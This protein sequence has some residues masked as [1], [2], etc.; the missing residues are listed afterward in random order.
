MATLQARWAIEELSGTY[1]PSPQPTPRFSSWP[2]GEHIVY[3]LEDVSGSSTSSDSIVVSTPAGDEI[4]RI[5]VPDCSH[6][7][8]SPS[9]SML[10]I[11]DATAEWFRIQIVDLATGAIME[12]AD[13]DGCHTPIWSPDERWIAADCVYGEIALLPT[14][15]FGQRVDFDW[16]ALNLGGCREPTWSPDGKWIAFGCTY[17]PMPTG[18]AYAVD[19]SCLG[20][21]TDCPADLRWLGPVFHPLAWFPDSERIIVKW[22]PDV[23]DP[24]MGPPAFAVIDATAGDGEPLRVLG[25]PETAEGAISASLSADGSTLAYTRQTEPGGLSHLHV[26]ALDSEEDRVVAAGP[27]GGLLS[28]IKVP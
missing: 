8:L 26:V 17:Q 14:G 23:W 15:E 6:S 1:T 4:D 18:E 20:A 24:S 21:S 3:C 9:A 27:L 19:V 2:S 10:A 25:Q 13:S 7:A 11:A 28:W 22:I 12:L 5:P 16:F